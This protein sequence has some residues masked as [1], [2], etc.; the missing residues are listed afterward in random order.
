MAHES[1]CDRIQDEASLSRSAQFLE[2][3]APYHCFKTACVITSE[4]RSPHST[5]A[6]NT[7]PVKTIAVFG[8]RPVPILTKTRHLPPLHYLSQSTLCGPY[9]PI[10]PGRGQ[11][12]PPLAS[13][14]VSHDF[15]DLVFSRPGSAEGADRRI[16][17]A[18]SISGAGGAGGTRK[19]AEEG[20]AGEGEGPG[21]SR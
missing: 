20:G 16:R 19:G 3:S 5:M 14:L 21:W 11:F 8:A 12:R 1:P 6:S 4:P 15:R 9:S 18:A 10:I 17:V 2:P 7:S 13:D